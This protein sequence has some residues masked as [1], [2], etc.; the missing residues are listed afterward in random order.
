MIIIKKLMTPLVLCAAA[1]IVACA[2]EP[3]IQSGE[4]AEVIMGNL[5]KV[6]NSRV[7]M[8]YVDRDGDYDRYT[9]VYIAPLDVDNV[10]IVQPSGTSTSMVNRYNTEWELTAENKLQ[11]QA[12]YKEVME[13]ELAKD[14]AFA[15]AQGGGDD[16]L[17]I[18]GAITQIAPNAPKDDFSS[19]GAGRNRVY[20]ASSGSIDITLAFE[21]GDSG[22]VL[23]IIKDR[24]SENNSNNWGMNNSVT[25]MAE[26]RRAFSSWAMR[27]REGL[28]TLKALDQSS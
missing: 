20:T 10:E 17:A 23:A 19:R 1:G 9:R 21:D 22:D 7:D 11:L 24:R 4:D 13:R 5:N 6:N 25:N 14:G 2:G 27:V 3:T 16:V 12:A 28:Q 18:L 15:I 8:A 26:V